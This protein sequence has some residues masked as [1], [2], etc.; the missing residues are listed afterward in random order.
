MPSMTRGSMPANRGVTPSVPLSDSLVFCFCK[1][2]MHS[3]DATASVTD[4]GRKW[5]PQG[6]QVMRLRACACESFLMCRLPSCGGS[7]S[8]V[9]HKAFRRDH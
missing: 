8:S 7:T 3:D 2:L 6:M 1:R 9:A 4:V 5:Y